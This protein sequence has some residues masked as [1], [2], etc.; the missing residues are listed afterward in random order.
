MAIQ[1]IDGKCHIMKWNSSKTALSG[2][3]TCVSCD[4]LLIAW[5]QTHRHTYWCANK[6][7]FKKPGECGLAT[8]MPGLKTTKPGLRWF[9]KLWSLKKIL[10]RTSNET[11]HISRNQIQAWN[12]THVKT[13]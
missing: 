3:Y 1:F 11:W 4:L 10:H 6:N 13:S 5:G 7:D 9:K 12:L 8:L 2:Y